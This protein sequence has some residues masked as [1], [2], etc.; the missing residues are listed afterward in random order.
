MDKDSGVGVID[1]SVSILEA[2]VAS[3][4]TLADLVDRTG[5][6]RPTAH[7]LAQALEAHGLVD[8]DAAGRFVLGPRIAAWAAGA[9]ALQTR[10]A[11]AVVSLRDATGVSAQV[12]RRVGDQRLCIAA[13][14]PAAGLR[15]TVPVGS[16]LTL[17]AG[18]AAQVLTAWLEPRERAAVLRGAAFTAKDLDLV[19]TRGWAHSVGQREPGVASV[20]VPAWEGEQL[21][22][23]VSVSGPV[24][25]LG[26]VTPGVRRALLEAARSLSEL[27]E[28]A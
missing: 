14:E 28:P 19:R 21:V 22:A 3:P 5:I 16:L 10:A 9:D 20:S 25:R 13:A 4:A 26:R 17:R 1:K 15:D 11:A 6:T 18:S 7:R 27:G 2:V 23:A 12:Y 24:E 8:R